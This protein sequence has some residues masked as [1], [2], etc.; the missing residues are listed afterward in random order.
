[1]A[2]TARITSPPET[3]VCGHTRDL[4]HTRVNQKYFS[5]GQHVLP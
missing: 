3:F 4:V 5:V 2:A 1:M